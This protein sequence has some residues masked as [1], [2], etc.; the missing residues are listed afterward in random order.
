MGKRSF[1]EQPTGTPALRFV[2]GAA[3]DVVKRM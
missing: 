3:K 2:I 1:P